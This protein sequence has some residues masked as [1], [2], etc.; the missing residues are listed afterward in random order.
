MHGAPQRLAAAGQLGKRDR[1]GREVLDAV[2]AKHDGIEFALE[3]GREHG[4]VGEQRDADL[5]EVPQPTK[6]VVSERARR[7]GTVH[8]QLVRRHGHAHARTDLKAAVCRV[9]SA[10]PIQANTHC[11]PGRGHRRRGVP[12]R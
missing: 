2:E 6:P 4:P 5:L 1:L 12:R 7:H 11:Q 9:L 10:V 8:E 3:L